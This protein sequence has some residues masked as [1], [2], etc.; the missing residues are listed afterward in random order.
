MTTARIDLPVRGMTCASCVARIEQG[1]TVVPGVLYPV[2]GILMSLIL[3]GPPWL[4]APS[5]WCRTCFGSTGLDP[6]SRVPE[7]PGEELPSG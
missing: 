5:Q 4:S 7:S 3:A 1:L 6:R 2:A